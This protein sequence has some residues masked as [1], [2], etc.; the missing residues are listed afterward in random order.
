MTRKYKI[1]ILTDAIKHI[2]YIEKSTGTVLRTPYMYTVKENL[3]DI[4]EYEQ[5][6]QSKG[7]LNK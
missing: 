5:E 7:D 6:I 3:N 2:E 1:T 4:L